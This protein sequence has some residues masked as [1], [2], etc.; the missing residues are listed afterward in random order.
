MGAYAKRHDEQGGSLRQ[1]PDCPVIKMV[2]MIMGQYNGI[3]RRQT[4]Q[5][6]RQ[7]A[8]IAFTA[9]ERKR[10]RGAP[11]HR[12]KKQGGSPNFEQHS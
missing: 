1:L 5:F 6:N 7:L 2:I 9:D 8:A 11:Q 10:R 3:Q 4:G 12:V